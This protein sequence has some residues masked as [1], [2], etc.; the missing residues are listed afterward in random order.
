MSEVVKVSQLVKK[1]S[2]EIVTGDEKSLDRVIVTGDIS[3]PGLEL[4]VILIIIP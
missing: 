2:L 1:L 3:R 4:T